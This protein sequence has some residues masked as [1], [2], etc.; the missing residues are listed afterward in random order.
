M[1]RTIEWLALGLIVGLA[2]LI[3]GGVTWRFQGLDAPP[4]AEANPD[5][6]DYEAFANQVASGHGYC[7]EPGQPSACRPPGTSF[8]LAPI[9]VLFGHSYLAAR[10]WFCL[11]ST[12][13]VIATWWL[14]RLAFGAWCG[15]VAALM[16]AL[17]PGHFYYAMHFL[18]EVPFA[19]GVTM[20]TALALAT[21]RP[22]GSFRSAGGSGAAWGYTI[23]VRPNMLLGV[24]LTS[25]I[26]LLTPG[27]W[28]R[29]A[30]RSALV[31]GTAALV[32]APWIARNAQ[33][34]GKPAVCTIVG[35]FTFWG[36][37]NPIVVA[38]PKVA[39]SWIPTHRLVDAA[40][41]LE[42]DEVHREAAAW[43]YG[44]AFV[45]EHPEVLPRLEFHKLL[46]LILPYHESENATVDRAFRLGWMA[47]APF[48][49]IGMILGLRRR[50][51]QALVL[52]VPVASTILTAII[53]YGCNRFRD[54]IAPILVSFAA[55]G[56]VEVFRRGTDHRDP[57]PRART[58]QEGSTHPQCTRST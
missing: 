3:R 16:L 53:F 10:V 26:L 21:V 42:G 43:A 48:V 50:T 41:P 18:S 2:L 11:L 15:L 29:R 58:S 12:G 22:D 23:L 44:L 13:T 25:L 14:A 8:T 31:A 27:S 24:A 4:K 39:G 37:H 35:G 56:L 47:I 32:V 49:A 52:L 1:I 17:Y 30:G 40:H 5:Q 7:V 36:S 55:C 9:Y 28:K 45:K 19:L 33:V 20:A 46:R 34:M 51:L 38:D 54:G 57:T 6:L